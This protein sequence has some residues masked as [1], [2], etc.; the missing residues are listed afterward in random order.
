MVS[1]TISVKD[2]VTRRENCKALISFG[3]MA[4]F[5][6]TFDDFLI[7]DKEVTLIKIQNA[8]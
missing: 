8:S 4:E 3:L 2:E 5:F 1:L 7:S 6:K